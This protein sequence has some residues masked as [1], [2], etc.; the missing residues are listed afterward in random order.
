MKHLLEYD[1]YIKSILKEL[2]SIIKGIEIITINHKSSERDLVTEVD[3]G[4]EK[5]LTEKILEKFPDH[6]IL[7]EETFIPNTIYDRKNLWVIDPIDGTTNF[8]KQKNDYCTIISYFEDGKP[9][10]SYIY[11]IEKDDLY[12][13]IKGK[14]VF[15]NDKKLEKPKNKT[16]VE[17]LISTDIRRMNLYKNEL[18][19]RLVKDSFG[20]RSVGSSGLDGSRVLSGRT[21]AYINY[22][23]GPWDFAPFYLMADELDL[24]FTD[25]KGNKVSLDEHSEFIVCTKKVFEDVTKII[26]ELS[27]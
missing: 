17:S 12:Y 9:A 25:L 11:E 23:G 14:G 13:S 15:L 24:V 21:G 18:F 26:N 10:L 2:P 8:V 22:S 4:V 19:G 1:K 3:E 5:F 27:K 16:L 20:L 6:T 7:G